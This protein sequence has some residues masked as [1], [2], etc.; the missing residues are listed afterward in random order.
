MPATVPGAGPLLR[1]PYVEG[2]T[3]LFC[4][5]SRE[6]SEDGRVWNVGA[7]RRI[8]LVVDRIDGG[9]G[10][11]AIAMVSLSVSDTQRDAQR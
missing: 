8:S 9:M 1:L 10:K 7:R 5:F 11:G 6:R 4:R 2:T 3:T